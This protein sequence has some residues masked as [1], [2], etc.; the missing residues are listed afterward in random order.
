MRLVNRTKWNT[1]D[2]EKLCLRTIKELG[3]D[4]NRTIVIKQHT[5]KSTLC[6]SGKAYV[7]YNR[8]V[9]HVPRI[10]VKILEPFDFSD[11]NCQLFVNLLAHEFD[12]N[13]GLYHK[14]MLD[15]DYTKDDYEWAKNYKVRVAKT[16]QKKPEGYFQSKLH[17]RTL[18]Q[19]KKWQTKKKRA[20]DYLKKLRRKKSQYEKEL[21]IKEK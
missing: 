19:I 10:K 4:N 16:K 11:E 13:K 7:R 2:L 6:F 12:H 3:I 5:R 1:S 21:K 14:D 9:V 17:N 8:V 20:E 15:M 18:A